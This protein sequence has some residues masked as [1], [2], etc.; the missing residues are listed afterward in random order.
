MMDR[1]QLFEAMEQY[2]EVSDDT[3]PRSQMAGRSDE[4]ILKIIA[5]CIKKKKDVCDLGYLTLDD[6]V[7]Y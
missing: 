3:F 4:E 5:E 6:D 7:M 2:E 1:K